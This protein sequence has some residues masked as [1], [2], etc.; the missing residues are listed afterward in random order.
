MSEIDHHKQW[1]VFIEAEGLHGLVNVPT[2][3]F[4]KIP[5]KDLRLGLINAKQTIDGLLREVGLI[6]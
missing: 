5:H 4:D 6:K 3:V 2:E 1:R